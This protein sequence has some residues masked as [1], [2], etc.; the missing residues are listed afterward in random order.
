[1]AR[2]LERRLLAGALAM[3]ALAW[4]S[5]LA[6]A[7][8]SSDTIWTVA[9]DGVS[10]NSPAGTPATEA[11]IDRPRSIFATQDG[12]FVWAQ[13][14]SSLVLKVG[15]TGAVTRIAGTGAAGF[16]GDGGPATSAQINFVHSASPTAD[17]G[18]LLADSFNNRIRYVSPSGTIT[19]VAG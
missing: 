13:P 18:Y 2:T 16:S 6:D 10:G 4:P 8:S 17:G 11:S 15:P 12:G 14:W 1:M 5:G 3:L 7:A 9:G 19:T